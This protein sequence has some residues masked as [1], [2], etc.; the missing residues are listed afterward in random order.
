MRCLFVLALSWSALAASQTDEARQALGR[1]WMSCLQAAARELDDRASPPRDV[2]YAVRGRCS[3]EGR[4]YAE[5]FVAG[6]PDDFKARFMR[7]VQAKQL[8]AATSAVLRER[9]R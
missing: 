4:R 5:A 9:R 2:A 7:D 6:E 8:D 3:A 1:E